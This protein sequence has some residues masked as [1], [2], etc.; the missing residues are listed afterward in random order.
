[1]ANGDA[2]LREDHQIAKLTEFGIGERAATELTLLLQERPTR[3]Q[4][5]LWISQAENRMYWRFIPL[6]L[7]QW[8]ASIAILWK[9]FGG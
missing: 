5:Q 9:V 1:M 2:F 7:A 6:W 8:G 4:A 3:D